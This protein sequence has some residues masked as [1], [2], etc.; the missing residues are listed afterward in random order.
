MPHS[1]KS[2]DRAECAVEKLV[3]LIANSCDKE[4]F[5][6]RLGYLTAQHFEVEV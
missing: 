2:L 1:Q 6:S 3:F 4:Y 5:V